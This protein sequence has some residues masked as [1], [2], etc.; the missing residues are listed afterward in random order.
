MNGPYHPPWITDVLCPTCGKEMWYRSETTTLAYY[1]ALLVC[2]T[3]GASKKLKERLADVERGDEVVTPESVGKQIY[4][5]RK[6]QYS[7]RRDG[8]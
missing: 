3:C 4:G 6:R 8:K 1:Y 7:A 5:K 2:K